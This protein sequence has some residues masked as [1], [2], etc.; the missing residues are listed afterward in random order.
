MLLGITEWKNLDAFVPA[1]GPPSFSFRPCPLPARACNLE[2]SIN[3]MYL[4]SFCEQIGLAPWI[5]RCALDRQIAPWI[6][7]KL[8]STPVKMDTDRETRVLH[9]GT[10]VL[11]LLLETTVSEATREVSFSSVL[12]IRYINS[13][14]SGQK[15]MYPHFNGAEILWCT[16]YSPEYPRNQV[17][18]RVHPHRKIHRQ[19]SKTDVSTHL[20]APSSY[21]APFH[22]C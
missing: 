22:T 12:W 19:M 20:R 4:F 7:R 9:L 17:D 1:P 11:V 3:Q 5:D 6:D 13:G 16:F 14:L 2:A 10:T 21:D 8:P 15:Q 18:V